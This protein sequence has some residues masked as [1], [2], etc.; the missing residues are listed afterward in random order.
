MIM[1]AWVAPGSDFPLLSAGVKLT[2]EYGGVCYLGIASVAFLLFLPHFFSCH[3]PAPF[4]NRKEKK[5][6]SG[7]KSCIKQEVQNK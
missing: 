5:S 1:I 4:S 6:V 3:T 7:V 2:L